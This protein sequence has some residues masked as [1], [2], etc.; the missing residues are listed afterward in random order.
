MGD[1][2]A[3]KRA[4]RLSTILWRVS[5]TSLMGYWS[6]RMKKKWKKFYLIFFKMITLNLFINRCYYYRLCSIFFKGCEDPYHVLYFPY[7]ENVKNSPSFRTDHHIAG[8]STYNQILI[9]VCFQ[10][11][12]RKVEIPNS[13]FLLHTKQTKGVLKGYSQKSQ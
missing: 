5:H 12:R 7:T 13:Y 2:G 8:R 6:K 1:G 3:G 10:R 11:Y 4:Q 9:T